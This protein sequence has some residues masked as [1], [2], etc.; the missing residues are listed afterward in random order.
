MPCLRFCLST[1]VPCSSPSS[2]VRACYACE[3]EA[4]SLM[5]S[6]WPLDLY[7]EFHKT[8]E[9]RR[10]SVEAACDQIGC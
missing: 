2:F 9:Q 10:F 1:V 3:K 4:S 6:V 5:A 8:I 7:I